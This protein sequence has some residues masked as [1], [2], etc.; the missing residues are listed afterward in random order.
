MWIREA[1][2]TA[3]NSPDI[4]LLLHTV[5]VS[6]RRSEAETALAARLPELSR[7]EAMESPYVLVGSPDEIAEKLMAQRARWGITHYT[8]RADAMTAFGPVM[9]RLRDNR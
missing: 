3:E 1:S 6:P 2:R 7:R 5:L 8:V 4:Q 9:A